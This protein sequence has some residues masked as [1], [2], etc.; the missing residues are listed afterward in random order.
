MPG[1]GKLAI[2]KAEPVDPRCF[3][4]GAATWRLTDSPERKSV[5][6]HRLFYVNR[7]PEE[8]LVRIAE[9]EVWGGECVLPILT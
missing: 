5:L 3:H 9:L 1:K 2:A 7:G 6:P 8:A 4:A